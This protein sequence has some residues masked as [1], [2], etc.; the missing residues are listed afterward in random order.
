MGEVETES[1]ANN[2]E[3]ANSKINMGFYFPE[4]LKICQLYYLMDSCFMSGKVTDS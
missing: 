1:D 2:Y 4:P 3:K